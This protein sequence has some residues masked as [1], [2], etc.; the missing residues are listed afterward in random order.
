MSAPRVPREGATIR[1]QAP[2]KINLALRVL[3]RRE[4]GYH[5]LDTLFQAIS[6]SDEV[7]LTPRE[8][9]GAGL[10]VTGAE[11]G[12]VRENL[13]L[14]AAHA[15]QAA[16]GIDAGIEIRLAKRIPAGAGLGGGS[17]DAGA[18]LRGLE[19]LH[20]SPLGPRRLGRLGATLGADVPFFTG[21]AALARGRG[22]GDRLDPLPALPPRQIIVAVPQR[23]V[24]TAAAYR[25]LAE[26]RTGVGSAPSL[27]L[28]DP[29]T[30][31]AVDELAQNDFHDVVARRVPEV[32]AL[33]EELV[34]AGLEGVLLSGSGSAL[35]G[36]LPAGDREASLDRLRRIPGG[37]EIFEAST[38]PE[39]PP[40]GH[41]ATSD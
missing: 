18:V 9:A 17:S 19:A 8:E 35:F 24:R 30:W 39:I 5:E 20:G 6:L 4:D 33:R 16:T 36:F 40:P 10:Q 15:W 1:I 21:E 38:L 11:L 22:V 12:P 7:L 26:A 29:L 41:E 31:T 3:D 25:W 28:P 27:V 14:R 32:A 34:D 2:A 37:A 23:P 13:A